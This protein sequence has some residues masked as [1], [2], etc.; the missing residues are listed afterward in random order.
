MKVTGNQF[1]NVSSEEKPEVYLDE[2]GVVSTDNKIL[3]FCPWP[4]NCTIDTPKT[5]SKKDAD[6]SEGLDF[7]ETDI[8]TPKVPETKLSTWLDNLPDKCKQT[9]FVNTDIL[10]KLLGAMHRRGE[11]FV[12]FRVSDDVVAVEGVKHETFG[13]FRQAVRGSDGR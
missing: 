13:Y 5:I 1:V 8:L 2:A 11:T 10:I 6:T 4:K 12:E 9:F 7:V 3:L